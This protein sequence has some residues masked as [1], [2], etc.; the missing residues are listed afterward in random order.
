MRFI[1]I[2]LIAVIFSLRTIA[3]EGSTIFEIVTG[4]VINEATSE[5]VSY[6]N[7]G[8]ENTLIGTASNAEGNFQLKVPKDMVDR[9]IY[10]SAVGFKNDTFPVSQLFGMQHAIIKMKPISYD[11]ENVDIE[12]QSRV[13]QRILSMASENTPYNF[14]AGPFNLVCNYENKKTVDDTL[15]TTDNIE[16]LIYDKTGYSNPS[17]LDAYRWRNYSIDKEN[18]SAADFSF[19]GGSTNLDDLLELDLVRTSSSVLDPEILDRFDLKLNGESKIDGE[20]AWLIAFKEKK[21]TLSGS[22]DFYATSYAG[23]ITILKDDYSV[24]KITGKVKSTVNNRQGKSLA[25]SKLSNQHYMNVEYDFA[26]SYNNL[27]P[28]NI[29]LNRTYKTGGHKVSEQSSLQI[30]KVQ[31]KDITT[32]KDREYYSGD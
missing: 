2:I 32:I 18:L 16:V 27:K 28:D 6:T 26:I 12:A 23:E 15:Q 25:V 11:I 14:I 21:P 19:A 5:P 22:Q 31:V 8:L 10:F 30:K 29:L 13:M 1:T 24:Y 3:Q 9:N 20:D 4:Q 17:K 7:I